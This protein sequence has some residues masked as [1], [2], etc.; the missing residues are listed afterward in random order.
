MGIMGSSF[1]FILGSVFGIY[2]AQNYNVP[3]IQKLSTTGLLIA[4]HI[5]ET[6][7]KPKKRDDENQ[8][9]GDWLLS[10]QAPEQNHNLESEGLTRGT[11]L[12][13]ATNIDLCRKLQIMQQ[14]ELLTAGLEYIAEMSQVVPRQPTHSIHQPEPHCPQ[15]PSSSPSCSAMKPIS[16]S[17]WWSQNDDVFHT[18][19]F[20]TFFVVIFWV[21]FIKKYKTTTPL[22][23]CPQGHWASHSLATSSP[24]AHSFTPTLWA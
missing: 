20:V 16:L 1:S 19:L 7:R 13:I 21:L 8:N 2:V 22:R 15:V 6:Y 23:R 5:E 18:L 10:P 4:K 14:R 12:P 9:Q 3:N 24:C 17:S 11:Q